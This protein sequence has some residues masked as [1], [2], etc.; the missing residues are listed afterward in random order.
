MNR[1]TKRS[2]KLAEENA[3]LAVRSNKKIVA[4]TDW[5]DALI[6][7]CDQLAACKREIDHAFSK[8][9]AAHRRSSSRDARRPAPQKFEAAGLE[10]SGRGLCQ[11][12]GQRRA[13]L[14]QGPGGVCRPWAPISKWM[15]CDMP[16][17][18]H[19][20]W[21]LLK[22]VALNGIDQPAP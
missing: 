19:P 7:L 17:L 3:D 15:R 21:V 20:R 11:C 1:H 4:D 13:E 14:S 18:M 22:E 10:A 12:P 16:T 9:E 2:A 8:L 6:P 5:P